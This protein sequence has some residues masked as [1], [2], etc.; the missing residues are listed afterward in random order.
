MTYTTDSEQTT[1]WV[2]SFTY[3]MDL[4]IYLNPTLKKKEKEKHT[5]GAEDREQVV[6]RLSTGDNVYNS[7]YAPNQSYVSLLLVIP[8]R[9]L[10]RESQH[11]CQQRQQ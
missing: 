5:L 8:R 1:T 10:S 11:L 4:D 6:M 7:G 2:D 3:T 9:C